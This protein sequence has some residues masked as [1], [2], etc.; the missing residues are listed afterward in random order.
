MILYTNEIT[1]ETVR[2]SIVNLCLQ[3][4][5]EVVGSVTASNPKSIKIK[6]LDSENHYVNQAPQ[7]F[8]NENNSYISKLK[9]KTAMVITGGGDLIVDLIVNGY[10]KIVAV[11]VNR[12]QIFVSI[13]KFQTIKELTYT[14]FS[15]FWDAQNENCFDFSVINKVLSDSNPL[16]AATLEFWKGVFER[17]NYSS[18]NVRYYCIFGECNFINHH[19]KRSLVPEYAK[20]LKAFKNAKEM[21]N[22]PSTVCF[23]LA[24]ALKYSTNEKFDL[25]HLSNIFNFTTPQEYIMAVKRY[26]KN[27]NSNGK[28]VTYVIQLDKEWFTHDKVK[29]NPQWLNWNYLTEIAVRQQVYQTSTVY[30]ELMYLGIKLVSVPTGKGYSAYYRTFYDWIMIIG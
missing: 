22:K 30:R 13:L 26:T 1:S 11:D 18:K 6:Y 7:L 10:D 25:I 5:S 29:I 4:A 8:T 28:I 17:Y 2:S 19:T 3:N 23:R 16:I 21:L 14:E 27:L 24:D 20:N 12:Y 9:G 15:R